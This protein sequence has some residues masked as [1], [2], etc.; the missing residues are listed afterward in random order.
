MINTRILLRRKTK[1]MSE[2]RKG[3]CCTCDSDRAAVSRAVNEAGRQAETHG[4]GCTA[5]VWEAKQRNP[6]LVQQ[7]TESQKG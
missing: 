7:A 5:R 1:A 3:T 2:V 6:G 4:V